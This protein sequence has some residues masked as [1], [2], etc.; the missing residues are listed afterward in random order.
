MSDE[1]NNEL[2]NFKY[3]VPQ[4]RTALI[5]HRF[6]LYTSSSAGFHFTLEFC[7]TLS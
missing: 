2:K 6:P 7:L 1:W 3:N 4:F 5:A